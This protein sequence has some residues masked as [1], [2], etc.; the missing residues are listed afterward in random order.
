MS[1]DPMKRKPSG[2]DEKLVFARDAAWRAALAISG[3]SRTMAS[4]ASRDAQMKILRQV[5]SR[6]LPGGETEFWA[7]VEMELRR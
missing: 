1:E 7:M 4:A 2:E 3:N 6:V 5:V